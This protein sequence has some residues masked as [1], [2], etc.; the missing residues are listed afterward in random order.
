MVL[1]FTISN[2]LL[3]YSYKSSRQRCINNK[4]KVMYIPKPCRKCWARVNKTRL[5][6]I[7]RAFASYDEYEEFMATSGGD[8]MVTNLR[9]PR[10]EGESS[11]DEDETQ[12]DHWNWY[13]S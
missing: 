10:E 6:D 1:Y 9:N 7:K 13:I 11:E 8:D 12:T 3:R 5:A 2:I 4:H